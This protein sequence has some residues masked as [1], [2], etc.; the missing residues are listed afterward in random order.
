[1]TDNTNKVED[2]NLEDMNKD[3]L[4]LNFTGKATLI[5]ELEEFGPMTI[6]INDLDLVTDLVKFIMDNSEDE[7]NVE[8]SDDEMTKRYQQVLDEIK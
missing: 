5:L 2:V 8:P 1:M 4:L 7:F 3:G 6:G